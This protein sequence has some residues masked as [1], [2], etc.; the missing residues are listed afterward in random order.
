MHWSDGNLRAIE[1]HLTEVEAHTVGTEEG[2]LCRRDGCGGRLD[3]EEPENCSCH[4]NP[5]CAA[6]TNVL[7]YCPECHW[8]EDD[9]Q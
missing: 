5:P 9:D 1:K 4:I 8:R 7:M 3:T 2:D 6:C